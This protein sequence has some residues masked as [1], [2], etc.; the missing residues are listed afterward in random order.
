[1][2]SYFI[3]V[4]I[5]SLCFGVAPQA[6]STTIVSVEAPSTASVGD[7]VTADVDVQGI[8][9]LYA[10]QFDLNFNP[11]VLSAASETEGS[12]LPGGGA[13]FFISG[14]VDNVGGTVASTA[15]TLLT[16][17]PGVSGSGPLAAFTFVAAGDGTSL[18]T[19]SNA[20]FLDSS[21]NQID[22][23]LVPGSISVGGPTA[24][25]EPPPALVFAVAFAVAAFTVRRRGRREA[26]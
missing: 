23:H 4:L 9:D 10:F 13:T 6:N 14:T 1:M 22:V 7:L 15:D 11:S 19:I 5:I 12:F 18:F 26:S 16:D 3:P 24:V 21:L 8:T 17:I 2:K 25:P 20:L